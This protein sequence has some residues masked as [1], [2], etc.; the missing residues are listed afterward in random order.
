MACRHRRRRL[1]MCSA[2]EPMRVLARRGRRRCGDRRRANPSFLVDPGGAQRRP[3]IEESQFRQRSH[4]GSHPR[5]R[6]PRGARGVEHEEPSHTLR[7]MP[8]EV[9]ELVEEFGA[10][11]IAGNAALFVGAGL[12]R[13]AGYPSW[14]ELL[15][16]LRG[17]AGIPN[18][19]ADLP[20]VAQYYV[21]NTPGG[22][23]ALESHILEKLAAV[24]AEP[25]SGHMYMERL[26]VGDIWTTNY[27]C[28]LETAITDAN[29]IASDDALANRT[30]P[31]RRRIIKMHG[32]LSP[33][34]KPSWLSPPIITRSDYEEYESRH[35]RIWATLKAHYLTKT[36]LFLG[37][38]F[39]DPNVEVMLRLSRTVLNVARPEHYTVLRRPEDP[40]A[41]RLHQLQVSDLENSGVAVCEIDDF[42]EIQPIL[43]KLLRRTRQPTVFVSGS[44]SDNTDVKEIGRIIGNRLAAHPV[45]LAS[46]GGDSGQAVGYAFGAALRAET[47]YNPGL[48]RFYF[49]HLKDQAPIMEKRIGT[50][51]YTGQSLEEMR[52]SQLDEV[53]AM[54]VL[55]GS[56]RTNQEI[57]HAIRCGV[58]V[59]PIPSSGGAAAQAW[60]TKDV[61]ELLGTEDLRADDRRDWD[62]LGSDGVDKEI[63]AAAATRLLVRAMYVS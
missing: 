4:S 30:S 14:D 62:L 40:D 5:R 31:A 56:T 45:E 43:Q 36:F 11:A 34:G 17:D 3:L 18:D 63:V 6:R 15:L 32:S 39:A 53:R 25:L 49:R 29:V 1:A 42:E 24:K 37:F 58:P 8:V 13:N 44:E 19:L 61:T 52:D 20:L 55:G 21:L 2:T 10:A 57:D 60:R 23:P 38:S 59:V 7:V 47:R 54:L 33:S 12:S 41:L 51:V 9:R 26:P 48:I 16:D 35:P 46:F 22:R 28:L 27:D 50:V